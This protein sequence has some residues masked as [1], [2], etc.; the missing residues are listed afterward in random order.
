MANGKASILYCGHSAAILTT[1]TGKR[2]ALDPWLEGNPRCPAR[3]QDPGKLDFIGLS[4]GHSDHA[5]SALALAKM[6]KATVFATYEL[7]ML[8]IKDGLSSD[9]L[10]PMNKG[11]TID[12]GAG[13]AVTLTHAFHSSSYDASDRSTNYAGEPCG[14][15]VRLESGRCVYFAGDTAL[16]SDMA[17]IQKKFKPVLALLPIGDRF[18]MGPDDAAEAA[19]MLKPEAVIPIHYAT[20]P[21]LSGTPEQFGEELK[22]RGVTAKLVALEPG[23]EYSF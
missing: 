13:I 22:K 18:T 7:S 12:L 1:E 3:L 9:Q 16:F 6:T 10:Q 14:I 20:F 15:V 21:P 17:L 19:A 8:L 23:G 11:G 5:S 2:I 4:H